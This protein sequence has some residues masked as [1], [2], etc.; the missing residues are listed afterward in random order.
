MTVGGC[1]TNAA[2]LWAPAANSQGRWLSA[3]QN[4]AA[5]WASLGETP[6]KDAQ[7]GGAWTTA[8]SA[9]T[10]VWDLMGKTLMS[11]AQCQDFVSMVPVSTQ[12]APSGASAK[13]DTG[14]TQVRRGVRTWM[15]APRA[16]LPVR[17]S[18]TTLLARS[19]A[20]ALQATNLIG[21]AG[22]AGMLTN[23]PWDQTTANT[24]V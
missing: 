13:E 23:V 21:M 7:G 12:W 14:L 15:S 5:Q 1:A 16:Q 22:L 6:A 20:D 17:T 24:N 4:V 19:S 2:H 11:A 3:E 10:Q 18:A 8:H 9:R